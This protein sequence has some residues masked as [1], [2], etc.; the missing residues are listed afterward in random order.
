MKSSRNVFKRYIYELIG[1]MVFIAIAVVLLF[2]DRLS[3]I[4]A[5]SGAIV[6]AIIM[7]IV[8]NMNKNRIARDRDGSALSSIIANLVEKIDSPVMVVNETNN[9]VWCNDEFLSLS[10]VSEKH[11]SAGASKLFSGKLCFFDME[12]AYNKYVDYIPIKT[13]GSSY[14]VRVFPL[15]Y[16]KQRLFGSVWYNRDEIDKTENER[17]QNSIRVAYIVIDNSNEVSQ[18]MRENRR[19]GSA[20]VNN[21][22]IEWAKGYNAIL[23]EYER[24][25]YVMQFENRYMDDIVSSKFDILDKVVAASLGESAVPITLSIGVSL[26]KGTLHE[27]NDAAQ[28]M[29]RL[30]LQRGGAMAIVK[31]EN[32]EDQY[33]GNTKAV[34]R[35]TKIRS[36]LCRD[37]LCEQLPLCSNVII[38]GHLRPDFDSIAS[39][40]GI[41]KLVQSF[42]KE[43]CIV[44]DRNDRN[45]SKIIDTISGYPEYDTVFVDAVFAQELLTPETLVIITDASNPELFAARGVY[46]NASKVIVIDHH[47][48]NQALGSQVM[49]L[50]NI[51]PTA[52]SASELVCEILELAL[53]PNVLRQEEAQVLM[54]GILLDT[55][56]FSRDTGTRTYSACMYL[57]NAGAD[58][59]K[60]KNFFKSD[61]NQFKTIN[62]ISR[63]MSLYRDR[64]V[65]S[66]YDDNDNPENKVLAS[67]AADGMVE[68]DGISASFVLYRLE[69]GINLSARSDGTVNVIN[70]AKSIGGGGHFQSAGALIK[71]IDEQGNLGAVVRD[72][73]KAVSILKNAIDNYINLTT[74]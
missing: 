69:N 8:L 30:A 11:I 3:G 45:I 24:D 5:F 37:L 36:R 49:K 1:L 44:A 27:K 50:S 22:L 31:T 60:A 28:A 35:Q 46:E 57:K 19:F 73:D 63:N 70:I 25:K 55:Q 4:I 13:S 14:G 74:V 54:A 15:E 9:I 42:N 23:T 17:K 6:Y 29:L 43:Y 71:E 7:A 16:G 56:F 67:K 52:S 26:D 53:Q 39:N 61:M 2:L 21:L 10:E 34:Q 68:I 33:G 59:G 40:I 72:M 64:F 65:I 12:S 41:A 47:A 38:M 32:G 48:V 66:T 62:S 18:E 51:D 58:A 20:T